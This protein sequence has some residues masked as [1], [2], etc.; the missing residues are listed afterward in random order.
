MLTALWL[1][2]E[3]IIYSIAY[4]KLFS[5]VHLTFFLFWFGF[6]F[7]I[8]LAYFKMR[9]TF[10]MKKLR[11]P[12]LHQAGS[13]NSQ[14]E[15]KTINYCFNHKREEKVQQGHLFSLQCWEWNNN[16]NLPKAPFLAILPPECPAWQCCKLL[17]GAF[18]NVT[19]TSRDGLIFSLLEVWAN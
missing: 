12:V 2:L 9:V 19:A 16:Y 4:G 13:P 18:R 11:S 5:E 1:F 6:A 10:Q 7:E 14:L 17:A 3:L 15:A 8:I